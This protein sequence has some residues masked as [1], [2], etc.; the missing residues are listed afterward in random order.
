MREKVSKDNS[1]LLQDVRT[2]SKLVFEK[3]TVLVEKGEKGQTVLRM[4]RSK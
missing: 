4:L 2:D 1:D 3:Q